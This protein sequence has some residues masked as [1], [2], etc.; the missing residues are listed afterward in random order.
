MAKQVMLMTKTWLG[1]VEDQDRGF[2]Q[3]MMDKFLHALEAAPQKPSAMCFYTEGVRLV[4]DNSPVLLSLKVLA[5][6]GVD[7]IVCQSCVH[8]YG[9]EDRVAV[10]RVGGMPD[11]VAAVTNA[12]SV[13]TV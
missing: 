7:L 12:D 4:I 6:M 1:H 9:L 3:A 5:D 2:G 8:Q 11:I 10:G 13:V